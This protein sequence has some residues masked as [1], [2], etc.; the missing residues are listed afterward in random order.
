MHVYQLHQP[1]H[2]EKRR[3]QQQ[4]LNGISLKNIEIVQTRVFFN[5]N[6]SALDS[7]KTSELLYLNV[8]G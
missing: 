6:F 1:V 2:R 3:Y 5:P 7:L 8:S 4:I